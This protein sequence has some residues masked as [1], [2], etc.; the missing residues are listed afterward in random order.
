M[1]NDSLRLNFSVFAHSIAHDD[2]G[3]P[4]AMHWAKDIRTTVC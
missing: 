2:F 4:I 3:K 1:V